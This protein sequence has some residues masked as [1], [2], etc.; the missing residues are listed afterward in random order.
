MLEAIEG[1]YLSAEQNC[2]ARND[3]AAS[4]FERCKDLNMGRKSPQEKKILSYEKDG[5]N[6]YG[7]SDK[8]SR[9][10]I[11]RRKAW[12][13]RT[14]RH[15]ITQVLGPAKHDEPDTIDSVDTTAIRRKSWK[16]GADMPL[17]HVVDSS[18]QQR[19][20]RKIIEAVPETSG[21]QREAKRR[22]RRRK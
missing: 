12:V 7:E 22:L 20:R 1:L 21:L 2:E 8:G 16:K 6:S 18:L 10:R 14:M 15:A 11:R 4:K 3:A 13:H 19:K 5:R 17:V 9:K